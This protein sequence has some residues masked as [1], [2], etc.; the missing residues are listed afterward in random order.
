MY[1]IGIA[2]EQQR[3]AEVIGKQIRKRAEFTP[4]IYESSSLLVEDFNHGKVN[5]LVFVK[6]EFCSS[7]MKFF[8][9]IKLKAPEV[10]ITIVCRE[11]TKGLKEE[12]SRYHN[13]SILTFPGELTNLNGVFHKMFGQEKVSPRKHIRFAARIQSEISHRSKK[14]KSVLRNISRGGACCEVLGA[15]MV[16]GEE[17]ALNVPLFSLFKNHELHA[18]V[19]WLREFTLRKQQGMTYQQV[20]FEF[21]S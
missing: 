4:L 1:T 17:V 5:G 3:F 2:S 8:H 16:L 12:V 6:D 14:V 9:S 11:A 13:A 15:R 19:V 7:H 21:A 18:K 20:G 10:P